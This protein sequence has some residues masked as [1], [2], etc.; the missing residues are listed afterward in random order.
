MMLLALMAC[1]RSRTRASGTPSEPS[2]VAAAPALPSAVER[3]TLRIKLPQPEFV[4]EA[5]AEPAPQLPTGL[6]GVRARDVLARVRGLGGRG[7]LVNVWASWC[8]AC[9]AEMPMLLELQKRYADKGIQLLFVSVDEATAAS[10]VVRLMGERGLPK[11]GL[12]AVG[13]LGYFKLGLSAIWQG[14]LPATFLY[15]ASG[16]L[17]YFWGTQAYDDEV[18]GVLDA[19]LAG[20]AIDGVANVGVLAP[21]Q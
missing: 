13:S 8:G 10:D 4:A 18:S 14:S 20:A 2:A 5:D 16:K 7:T 12:V 9:K 21:P 6:V 3:Q 11:P 17:R 19:F 1:S 15:D